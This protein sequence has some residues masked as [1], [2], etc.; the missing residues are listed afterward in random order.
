MNI[1]YLYITYRLT[2]KMNYEY[3]DTF[4]FQITNM[5]PSGGK[6]GSRGGGKTKTNKTDC[7]KNKEKVY[8]QKTVRH[9]LLQTEK[10]KKKTKKSK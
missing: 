3:E 7:Q 6:N 8:N 1:S 4:D 10:S 5:K 2:V 9:K